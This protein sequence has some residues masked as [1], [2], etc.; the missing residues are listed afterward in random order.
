MILVCS[1]DVRFQNVNNTSEISMILVCSLDVQFQTVNK[2]LG[3]SMI[4]VCYSTL[5]PNSKMRQ[6]GIRWSGTKKCSQRYEIDHF[7]LGIFAGIQPSDFFSWSGR[8]IFGFTHPI[9]DIPMTPSWSLRS[10]RNWRLVCSELHIETDFEIYGSSIGVCIDVIQSNPIQSNPF[11]CNPI[12]SI[13]H[14][15]NQSINQSINQIKSN[16]INFNQCINQF[17]KSNQINESIN[18]I[19][20]NQIKSNHS[21]NQTINK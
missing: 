17:I 5:S 21:T 1:L 16:Q 20:T 6:I 3:M 2:T 13:T 9:S 11:Q 8:G 4:L 18:Q 7:C 10:F 19:K 14:S 12:Q 15:F